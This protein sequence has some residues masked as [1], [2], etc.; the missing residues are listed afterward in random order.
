MKTRTGFW[1]KK[2]FLKIITKLHI[3]FQLNGQREQ[4][5]KVGDFISDQIVEKEL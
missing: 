5:L 2:N 4:M 1:L 3:L